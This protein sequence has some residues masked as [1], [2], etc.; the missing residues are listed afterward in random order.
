[1]VYGIKV[2]GTSNAMK[3]LHYVMVG[4]VDREFKVP[5]LQKDE[6]D[7][8]GWFSA[9]NLPSP[10][11]PGFLN[12]LEMVK[13]FL[14]LREVFKREFNK[15]LTESEEFDWVPKLEEPKGQFFY[16]KDPKLWFYNKVLQITTKLDKGGKFLFYNDKN[17]STLMSED[18][19]RGVL[20]VNN[21]KIWDKL[22]NFKLNYKEI[23][24]LIKET[25]ESHFK[26]NSLR[27]LDING[28]HSWQKEKI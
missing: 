18:L 2:V 24:T 10:L 25:V 15:L 21:K 23:Q 16:Y 7:K 22:K 14:N 12:S 20:W 17:G 1:M 26:R 19:E 5:K 13:P 8:Y 28:E 27:P 6:N 4:F 9:D 3:H 11:H